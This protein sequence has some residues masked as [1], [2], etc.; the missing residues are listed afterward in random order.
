MK[1]NGTNIAELPDQ[2]LAMANAIA[3]LITV[4]D[5]CATTPDIR[6]GFDLTEMRGVKG[7]FFAHQKGSIDGIYAGGVDITEIVTGSA[8][9]ECED[10]AQELYTEVHHEHR[11]TA[12]ENRA[13]IRAG[14]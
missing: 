4:T 7:V 3:A 11:T 6:A 1:I 8:W 2:L 12:A 5:V 13:D 10:Q 9:N 14:K